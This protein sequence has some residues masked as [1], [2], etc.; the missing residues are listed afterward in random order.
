MTL[1]Y[2][3]IIAVALAMDAFAV[4]LA[5][6]WT[7]PHIDTRRTIRVSASFGLFQG[8]MPILG[9]LAGQTI[10]TFVFAIDHW[11]AFGLLTGIGFKMMVD[12]IHSGEPT[13][14]SDPTVGIVLITLALATSIDAFVTGTSLAMMETPM[15]T[16]CG[17]TAAITM[18]LSAMGLRSGRHVR[19]RFGHRAHLLGG[20]FLCFLG[21]RILLTHLNQQ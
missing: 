17:V 19:K 4:S 18:G 15:W 16:P 2:I 3:F 11:V 9:W 10:H 14:K 20:I 21:I 1:P 6:G 5:I 7:I 8:G 13:F 12:G